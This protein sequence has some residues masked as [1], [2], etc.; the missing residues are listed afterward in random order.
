MMPG[1]LAVYLAVGD[2]DLR[3]AFDRLAAVTRN[4]LRKDP[5]S[6]ALFLFVNRKRNRLKCLWFDRNGY[7]ILYKRLCKGSTFHI[8]A[9]RDGATSVE[10]TAE[11]FARLLAALPAVPR[12]QPSPTLH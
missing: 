11:D 3:G 12:Q 5:E 1:N 6:G 9:V 7:V 4:V 2:V 8:P 10:I